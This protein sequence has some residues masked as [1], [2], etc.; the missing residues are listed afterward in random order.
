MQW[1]KLNPW[2][3]RSGPWVIG[4][5]VVSGQ[6][7]YILS[8]DGNKRATGYFNSFDEAKDYAEKKK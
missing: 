1:K 4:K 7:K 8:K 6:P 3:M 5:A 2:A